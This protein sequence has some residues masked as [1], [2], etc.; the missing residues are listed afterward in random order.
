MS[1]NKVIAIDIPLGTNPQAH[2]DEHV[3]AVYE[4]IASHFSSTRYKVFA[5]PH[6]KLARLPIKS[7]G[8]S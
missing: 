4:Q 6:E 7:P 3:H 1:Q 8:P 2:E 5:L